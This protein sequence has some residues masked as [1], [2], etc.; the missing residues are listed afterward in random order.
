MSETHIPGAAITLNGRY[1]RQRCEWCGKTLLDYDLSLVAV[2]VVPGEE[3]RGPGQYPVGELV[4]IDGN[5]SYPVNPDELRRDDDGNV[6]MPGDACTRLD[7]AV[8]K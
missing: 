2:Q 4:R 1:M 6:V 8:T 3:P 7:P 5:A